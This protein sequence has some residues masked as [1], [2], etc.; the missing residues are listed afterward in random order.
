MW[1]KASPRTKPASSSVVSTTS[2]KPRANWATGSP[3]PL[4]GRKFQVSV[5]AGETRRCDRLPGETGDSGR[6]R[7]DVIGAGAQLVQGGAPR[8]ARSR[9]MRPS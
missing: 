5:A 9:A 2:R 8:R 4:K 7:A 1:T 3:P 6:L